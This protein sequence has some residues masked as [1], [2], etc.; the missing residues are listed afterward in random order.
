[1][2]RK[3]MA[4]SVASD[5][6]GDFSLLEGFFDLSLHRVFEQV[7][8]GEFPGFVIGACP[9]WRGFKRNSWI[10]SWPGTRR[11]GWI[12]CDQQP[13]IPERIP[14]ADLWQRTPPHARRYRRQ[15]P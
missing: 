11:S 15:T 6:L 13:T 10:R 4:K 5:S 8:A 9:E 3:K 2:R 7:V 12:V 14:G 1:M